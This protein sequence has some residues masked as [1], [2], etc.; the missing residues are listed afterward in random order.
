M[1]DR[2][3]WLRKFATDRV[4]AHAVLFRHRHPDATPHFHHDLI[5]AWHARELMRILTMAFREAGKST[6]AE[7][8]ITI[9][10]GLQAFRNCVILGENEERACD[11]LLAIKHE[12]TTNE[13]FM[14]LFGQLQGHVWGV[15]KVILANNIIIQALG[16]GQEVRGMKH[17]DIRPD[18]LFCDDIEGKEHVRSPE[19]RHET[20]RWFFADVLPACDKN[21]RVRVQATPLDRDALPMTLRTSTGWTAFVY[22]IKYRSEKDGEWKPTWGSRYPL[23]WIDGKEKE[24]QSVGLHDD[25]MREY[26]CEAEDPTRKVF[27]EAM[28]KVEPR[29]HTWQPTYAFIDPART[30][31]A[32][33]ATTGWVVWSWIANRLIVWDGS[34]DALKPDEVIDLA[35]RINNKYHP[36]EIGVEKD[37][38]DEFLMQPLRQEMLKRRAIIPV[39][40]YKAPPGKQKFIESLQPFFLAGEVVFAKEL[41]VLK[42]QFL[43]Y[44]TGLI[45]GPNALAYAPRMRP[46]VPLYD[47]FGNQ[48]VVETCALWEEAPLWLA[49]NAV[50]TYTTGVLCQ[51]CDGGIHIIADWV[52]EGEAGSAMEAIHGH[53]AVEAAREFR[54]VAPPNH[55]AS[56]D[57]VGLRGA[58]ASLPAKLIQGGSLDAGRAQFRALLSRTLRDTPAIQIG[59]K[60]HWTLN[61]LA[62]GYCRELTADGK[63]KQEAKSGIYRV[64]MEGLEAFA[65][66]LKYGTMDDDAEASW[67]VTRGGRRYKTILPGIKGSSDEKGEWL[68]GGRPDSVNDGPRFLRRK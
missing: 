48:H 46:G 49:V 5:R 52:R 22:P 35:F 33:S 6:I 61:A 31:G 59:Y 51:F 30:T 63:L 27:T 39:Q 36:I 16:R 57:I 65:G 18:L 43:N 32:R 38:L 24:M 44:P 37:S 15:S 9:M 2:S 14:S 4:L 64:L 41:P 10:A 3:D 23:P 1:D 60:A 47:N 68:A 53:A 13:F 12:L 50:S 29:V 40:P 42:Q 17:L 7:E 55:F 11:R 26:M 25:F 20:R 56:Y 67:A 8:A 21:V 58:V 66:L 62:G 45:D 28:F 19:A 34:G 54:I